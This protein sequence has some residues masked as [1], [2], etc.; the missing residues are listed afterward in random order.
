MIFMPLLKRWHRYPISH[1]F[2]DSIKHFAEQ[3]ELSR[4]RLIVA[5]LG[6]L[7]TLL[8]YFKLLRF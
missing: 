7:F 4:F 6:L 1:E 3:K 8:K 2:C 5:I